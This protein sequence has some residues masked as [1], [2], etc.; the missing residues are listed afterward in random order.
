MKI[1]F[2]RTPK[3]RQFKYPPRY[4]DAEKERWEQRKKELG[5]SEDG[6]TDFSSRIN[7]NWNRFRKSDHS[8]KRKAEMSV[9]IYL[10]IVALLIYF[11]F[12]A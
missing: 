7:S 4:Y 1:V 10:F 11:I 2:F 3:P 9:L 6:K 12:F 8:R 5:L